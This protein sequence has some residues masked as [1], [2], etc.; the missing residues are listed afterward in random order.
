MQ[1]FDKGHAHFSGQIG[2]FAVGFMTTS[3][4]GVPK[5]ID[6]GGPGGEPLIDL[7]P[8]KFLVFIVLGPHFIGNRHSHLV[9]QR[10]VKAGS[11]GNGLGEYR[12]GSGS[13][14]AV[15]RLVPPVV[16]RNSQPF[17]GRSVE[18]HL[19][20]FFR[21]CHLRDQLFGAFFGCFHGVIPS[22]YVSDLGEGPA[23]QYRS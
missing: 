21:Q 6:V 1:T 2:I 4:A 18:F 23:K 12:S 10:G 11:H 15:E 14:H 9:H 13:G 5:D 20:A 22:F 7:C 16:F 19:S 3:P 17:N 8:A